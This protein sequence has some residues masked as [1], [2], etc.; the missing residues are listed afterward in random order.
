MI[1]CHGKAQMIIFI[2]MIILDV[3]IVGY[4]NCRQSVH[5]VIILFLC[6]TH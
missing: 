6:K 5:V 4:N 1:I 2:S 3:G